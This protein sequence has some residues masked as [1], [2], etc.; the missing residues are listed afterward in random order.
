MTV[1]ILLILLGILVTGFFVSY[2]RNISNSLKELCKILEEGNKISQKLVP[3][4]KKEEII[5]KLYNGE[6]L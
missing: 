3:K 2:L 1:S 4:T 6:Q 5:E